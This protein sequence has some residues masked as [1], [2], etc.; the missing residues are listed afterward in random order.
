MTARFCNWVLLFACPS[1]LLLAGSASGQGG[2]TSVR[3]EGNTLLAP[4]TLAELTS[5]VSQQPPLSEL[6]AL[7]ARIQNAYRDAGYGGVVAYVPPQEATNGQ[8][9]VR[10]VEGKI[11]VVRVTGNKHFATANI[12]AGLPHLREGSTP[13]VRAINRDIQLTNNNPAKHVNVSLAAGK[14]AGTIDAQV[15]VADSRPV[16]YLFGYNNTGTA[17]TGRHRV[18]IG[19]EH[20]NLFDRDHVGTLQLQTSPG[21]PNRVQI[22][23]AG[24]RVPLYALAAS[25]DAFVA[26]STVSNGK[27]ATPAG[28]LSF[29]GKGTIVG[30]RANRHLERRGDY[31]HHVT[32]GLDW[33]AYK[34]DCSIGDFGAAAC[35][36]AAVDVTTVPLTLSYTGQQGGAA[37]NYGYNASL[38]SNI[39]GSS[40]AT[41]EAARPG[42]QRRY[43]LS[44]LSG[45]VDRP[46]GAGSGINLRAE[47]QMSAD[48]LISAEKFGIGG[49]N[50]VRGYAERELAGDAGLLLRLELAVPAR[51]WQQ[52]V[53]LRPY[54]FLDHGLV[55]NHGDMP[56]S[57]LQRTCELTGTG[58]GVRL[59]AQKLASASLDIGRAMKRGPTSEPGDIRAHAALNLVF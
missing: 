44:R 29:T 3:V 8:I 37:L 19:V 14:E 59:S 1:L 27:T 46:L 18:S 55:R 24:Y 49:A 22:L 35:G 25:F 15:D 6:K 43:L 2:A 16:Q 40:Q 21:Y 9:V 36:S 10:V 7:A 50:S 51:E 56:C 33:R 30:L 47:A 5:A 13:S 57:G 54:L 34:D 11:A 32:L 4:Q 58:V 52:G 17:M 23:S 12:R 41:F 20:A 42:A 39:A 48:P 31:D 28:P 53:R 45:F 26:Y 38:A